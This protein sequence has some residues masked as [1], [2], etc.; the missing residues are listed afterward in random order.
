MTTSAPRTIRGFTLI[1]IMVALA[2]LGLI[3][4]AIYSSWYAIVRGSR[5]GLQAAA[6]AQRMRVAA[7]TL[8]EALTS[9]RSYAA[10]AKLYYFAA[11]NGDKAYLS[12]VARLSKSFP[13]S[14]RF[15]ELDVRRVTFSLEPAP[16][17]GKQL[18]LRQSPLLMD[19]SQDEQDHPAVLARDVKEFTVQFW[20]AHA[21]PPDWT[22]EWTQTNE[23][24]S[25]VMFSLAMGEDPSHLGRAG[26]M[27]VRFVALPTVT[28]QPGVQ[29]PG[30]GPGPPGAPRPPGTQ[31]AQPAGAS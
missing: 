31:P 12:F 17:S 24:P 26:H 22:D 23:L 19:W 29:A 2:L 15:G 20:D 18:V 28:V 8:E 27:I 13:R 4:A 5:T 9:A 30:P 7:R 16:D 14:G 11:E 3:V 6:A 10:N 21:T 1:E 25:L